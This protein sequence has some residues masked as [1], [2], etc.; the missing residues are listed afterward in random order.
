MNKI[1]YYLQAIH[2]ALSDPEFKTI[3]NIKAIESKMVIA[4]WLRDDLHKWTWW[5]NLALT[6]LPVLIMWRLI[7]R[8]RFLEILVY[9]FIIGMLSTFL[10]VLGLA[11][12]LWEYPDKFLPILPRLFPVNLVGLPFV[13][14]L[15]YQTFTEW[16]SFSM[17]SIFLAA[18]LAF[19]GEPVF[20]WLNLY[21]P[22]AWHYYYSFPIY[23]LM[24][25]VCKW[26]TGI[27]AA[28]DINYFRLKP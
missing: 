27:L 18:L 20:V 11:F 13:Y 14:M 19:V 2:N 6:I 8:R 5:L 15:V 22:L 26:L 1:Y 9:G 12:M 23:F 24:A 7:D 17:A 4:N 3:E 21:H 10:D 16:R 25:V 28:Q